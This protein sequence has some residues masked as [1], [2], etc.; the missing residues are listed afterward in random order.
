MRYEFA[1]VNNR[2]TGEQLAS[3]KGSRTSIRSYA[4]ANY[5][6]VQLNFVDYSLTNAV[7][8]L[9]VHNNDVL[10][11]TLG[12]V[13]EG[14]LTASEGF[15]AIQQLSKPTPIQGTEFEQDVLNFKVNLHLCK[16]STLQTDTFG[17]QMSYNQF[18]GMLDVY[19]KT[20]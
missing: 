12:S 8:T 13:E 7:D 20:K 18:T 14:L 15:E 5:K 6:G 9:A 17:I 2:E 3:L 10:K 11:A 19:V 4:H 1:T 16:Q